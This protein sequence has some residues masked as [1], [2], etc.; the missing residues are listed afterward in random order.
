[1]HRILHDRTADAIEREVSRLP[2]ANVTAVPFHFGHFGSRRRP[3]ADLPALLA[4]PGDGAA[5]AGPP[6][7]TSPATSGS[8]PVAVAAPPSCVPIGGVRFRQHVRIEGK[9]RSMRVQPR[10]EVA[11]LECVLVDETGAISIVF[12]GRRAVAG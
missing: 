1:W 12:L 2:H 6:P 3:A 4:E 11:T 9:V 7:V 10:A 8:G 5:P